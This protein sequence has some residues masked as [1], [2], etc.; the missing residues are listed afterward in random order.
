M[1]IHVTLC[2]NTAELE[3]GLTSNVLIFSFLFHMADIKVDLSLY[4]SCRSLKSSRIITHGHGT[5]SKNPFFPPTEEVSIR[6]NT[7]VL[8]TAK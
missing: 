1:T 8:F 3:Y 7:L 4:C 2:C 6:E 5:W